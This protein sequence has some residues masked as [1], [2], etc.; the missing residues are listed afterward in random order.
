[1]HPG[2]WG[3]LSEILVRY[4]I[5]MQGDDE[6]GS[7]RDQKIRFKKPRRVR[8]NIYG[9]KNSQDHLSLTRIFGYK[10]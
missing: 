3:R 9:W 6:T 5:K 2:V 10:K 4:F 1:M 7:A 8:K